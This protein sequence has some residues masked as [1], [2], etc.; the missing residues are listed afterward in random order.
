MPCF[1]KFDFST[2]SLGVTV[3]TDKSYH[4]L[5]TITNR[6]LRVEKTLFFDGK[7]ALKQISG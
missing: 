7:K 1:K 6:P 5:I 2:I 4:I 3:G